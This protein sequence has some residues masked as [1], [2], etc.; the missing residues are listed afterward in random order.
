VNA[1]ELIARGNPIEHEGVPDALEVLAWIVGGFWVLFGAI[2][3][4]LLWA[5]KRRA[6]RPDAERE[7]REHVAYVQGLHPGHGRKRPAIM[8]GNDGRVVLYP[9]LAG[10]TRTA[11]RRR[12]RGR[13]RIS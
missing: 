1:A 6:G 5:R 8:R 10:V 2:V 12:K 11:G 9:E 3:L 4:T 7:H 13:R